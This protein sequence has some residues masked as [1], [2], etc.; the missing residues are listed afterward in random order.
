MTRDPTAAGG[1]SPGMP[2]PDAFTPPFA[3]TA[4]S[5]M[6]RMIGKR[7]SESKQSAPHFYVS[8]D[9]DLDALLALRTQ[10]KQA[11]GPAAPTVNDCIVR[12]TALALREVPQLNAALDADK[13]R[14]YQHANI[15]VAVVT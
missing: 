5:T 14:N 11:Q 12:A 6:R 2:A 1:L 8:I 10:W 15:G 9:V 3:L 7:L 13:I 4:L